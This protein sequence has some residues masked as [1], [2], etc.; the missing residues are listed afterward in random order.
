MGIGVPAPDIL[1]MYSCIASLT[2]YSGVEI[3][4]ILDTNPNFDT[5]A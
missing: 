4:S 2:I 1:A 3:A 5:T